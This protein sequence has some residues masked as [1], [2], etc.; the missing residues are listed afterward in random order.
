MQFDFLIDYR[1]AKNREQGIANRE[2]GVQGV[3]NPP[4]LS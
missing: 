3:T 2:Q 4:T 1:G